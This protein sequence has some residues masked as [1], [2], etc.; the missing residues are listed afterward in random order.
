MRIHPGSHRLTTRILAAAASVACIAGLAATAAAATPPNPPPSH[1]TSYPGS[2]PP[3]AGSRAKT[4]T[5]LTNTTVEGEIHLKLRDEAGAQ[6]FATAVSTPGN[7]QYGQYL[8]PAQWKAQ[9]APSQADTDKLIAFIQSQG[10]VVTGVPASGMYVVFRGTVSQINA[11]FQVTEQTYSFQGHDL[12][13]PD[14]APTLPDDLAALVSGVII[15]QGRLLTHPDNST[16]GSDA[17]PSGQVPAPPVA[18][19]C[20][21]YWDEKEATVPPTQ[22]GATSVPTVLCGYTPAQIQAGYGV[23]DGVTLNATAGAGQTVAIID[24][25]ASP[26]MLQDA[27][28]Y[29]SLHGLP[30]FTSSTYSE[31]LPSVF[32]DQALCAQPSGWQGEESL[33]VEAVHSTAPGASVLYVGGFD[34]EGGLDLAMSKILDGKLATIVSNSYGFLGE[35]VP[36]DLL[37]GQQDIHIQAASEGIGL[38]FSSGDN[39]DEK[40]NLGFTSPDF[41][42]SS[43]FVTAV[44]GTD[45]AL[46]KS[47]NYLFETAWG[48]PRQEIVVEPNGS[49]GYAGP[50]PGDFV[51]GAGGGRSAVFAQPGYQKALVP[52]SLAN[53]MRVSPDVSAD[54]DSWTGFL[55]GFSP[56]TNDHSLN[57]GSFIQE[58]I[59]GTSLSC[60][61]TAGLMASAQAAAGKQIGFANPAV[62]L[63]A[64]APGAAMRDVKSPRTPINM[65][66][67]FPATGQTSVGTLGLDTSLVATPG[68]DDVTGV[69][70]MTEAF[71]QQV[72]AQH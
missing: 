26:T 41:P 60:P 3:W 61:L 38:Y 11:A 25:Y 19:P 44:G 2:V 53:G 50:L 5:P 65:V 68:Y 64:A 42:A 72:A 17:A 30:A 54:A 39:G 35:A 9:F 6:A 7:A 10:M 22:T 34:C 55:I 23:G 29:S 36:Q 69:G 49:L 21:H 31:N 58:R 12:I 71:A 14:R 66:R 13:G 33:D 37:L 28:Q 1:S 32:Y 24:A 67:A 56:I 43:P 63:A 57:T 51:A 70:S 40:A 48:T 4:G 59:G 27:N 62:Y 8:T 15:D 46:G 20:S 45:L 16:E 52:A 47:N 18:T